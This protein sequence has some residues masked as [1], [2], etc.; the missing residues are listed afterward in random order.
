MGRSVYVRHRTCRF[1]FLSG[2]NS[3]QTS[4]YCTQ[5]LGC[6]NGSGEPGQYVVSGH[7]I[8]DGGNT[9][10]VI[11]LLLLI[12]NNQTGNILYQTT[13]SPIPAILAPNEEGT[14]SQHFDTNTDLGGYTGHFQY[15]V[16]VLS[17]NSVGMNK[18]VSSGNSSSSNANMTSSNMTTSSFNPLANYSDVV[19]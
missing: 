19:L 11:Q 18:T 4:Y 7:V 15:S 10:N 9:S 13:F 1:S 12:T 17:E 8:N 14:F 2:I 16:R 6:T 3:E 5:L